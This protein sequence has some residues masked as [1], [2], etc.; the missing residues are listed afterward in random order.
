MTE[1]PAEQAFGVGYNFHSFNF[2]K[3]MG[4]KTKMWINDSELAGLD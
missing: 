4:E 1:C 2:V 3:R